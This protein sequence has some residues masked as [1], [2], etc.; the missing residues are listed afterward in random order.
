[1]KL[2]ELVTIMDLC[3]IDKSKPY[4]SL[5]VGIEED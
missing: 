5:I 1:M 2:Y 3:D 4:K